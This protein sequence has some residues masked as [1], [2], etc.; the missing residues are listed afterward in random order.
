MVSAKPEAP[1]ASLLMHN[2]LSKIHIMMPPDEAPYCL[3]EKWVETLVL[4]PWLNHLVNQVKDVL[5]KQG[6]E[7]KLWIIWCD[8]S[9]ALHVAIN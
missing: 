4:F 6:L 7:R 2:T 5:L 9:R 3:L 8:R 1:S